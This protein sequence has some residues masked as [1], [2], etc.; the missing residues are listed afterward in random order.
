M[1]I[2]ETINYMDNFA[3]LIKQLE[4]QNKIIQRCQTLLTFAV[5]AC[6]I[7]I[8]I[9]LFIIFKGSGYFTKDK[10]VIGSTSDKDELHREVLRLNKVVE[11]LEANQ[12]NKK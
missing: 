6:V 2:F 4:Q 3:L 8:V 9:M 1:K 10:I 5:I 12:S 11:R 7:A